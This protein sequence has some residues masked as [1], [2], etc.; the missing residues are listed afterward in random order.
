V[1]EPTPAA[2]QKD[3]V[4]FLNRQL[5]ETPQWMLDP[6][7]LTMIKPGAGVEQLR[8]V[9]E[10]TLN[11]LFDYARMQRLIE[12]NAANPKAYSLDDLFTD[13][14]S[15]VWAELR[16]RKTID[17]YRRNLQKVHVERLI[18]LMNP[19]NAAQP[20]ANFNPFRFGAAPSPVADPKKS[21]VISLARAHLIALRS[22]ITAALPATSDKMSKYHLQDVSVRINQ[23]LD[24]K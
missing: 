22:D 13:V 14:R 6:S 20:A 8:Q 19:A 17:T 1:Y 10:A 5:F 9:Q 4:A 23:A 18:A 15:G 2:L 12:T 7:V 24:P 21:D 11:S 16:T 3:A